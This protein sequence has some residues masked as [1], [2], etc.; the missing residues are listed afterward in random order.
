MRESESLCST[1]L[2][3]CLRAFVIGWTRST[4]R[5]PT[6]VRCDRGTH[7]RAVLGSI[8]AK[9]GV[10]IRPA[11]LE[12]PEQIGGVEQRDARY[13]SQVQKRTKPN[14]MTTERLTKIWEIKTW[15]K[16]EMPW[17]KPMEK[18]IYL[19]RFLYPV[20]TSF[21]SSSSCCNQTVTSRQPSKEALVQ[22]LRAARAAQDYIGAAKTFQCQACD[23]AKP[24]T[25]KVSP[26]RPYTFNHE[27]GV[28]VFEIV[29][30]VG[31]R[32]SILNAV[33]YGNC[34]PSSMYCERV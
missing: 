28:D 16:E 11:G 24:Q 10:T 18:L 29:E 4:A 22:M 5:W 32:F 31:M 26:P 9:N 17:K 23:N 2:H 3:A 12:A 1:S 15:K 7:N 13:V 8:L 25:H 30:S 19:K 14:N 20:L 34:V 33:F 27:V 21:S 6:L